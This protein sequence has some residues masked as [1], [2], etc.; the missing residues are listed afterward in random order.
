[1]FQGADSYGSE[2]KNGTWTGMMALVIRGKTDIAVGLF[3]VMKERYKV[4]DYL[5]TIT[6]A[7]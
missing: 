7:W 4:V 3:A 2:T 1:V 5:D 6:F